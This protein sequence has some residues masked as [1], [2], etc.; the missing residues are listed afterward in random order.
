MQFALSALL[1]LSLILVTVAQRNPCHDNKS[2]QGAGVTCE[3]VIIPKN[4]CKKCTLNPFN[5]LNGN[6]LDCR[7]IYDLE[8]AGCRAEIRKYADLNKDCDPVRVEQVKAFSPTDVMGLDYFI[9]SI[10]EECCDCI[11]RGT[12]PTD[13]VNLK[14][15]NRLFIPNRGNCPAHAWFDICK[16]WPKVRFVSRENWRDPKGDNPIICPVLTTWIRGPDATNWLQQDMVTQPQ[17]VTKFLNR[18]L[19]VAK[20]KNRKG[21]EACARLEK[22][23]D[24]I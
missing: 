20:C 16:I 6:F 3:K 11:P 21:W 9:Y 1:L 12:D 7:S 23:Q 8:N 17:S 5:N 22:A 15:Q 2:G 19:R 10:C 24:R 13:Y 14:A 18:F 4:L